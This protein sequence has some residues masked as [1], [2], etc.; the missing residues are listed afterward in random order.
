M[1]STIVLAILAAIGACRALA[2]P[3]SFAAADIHSSP[4]ATD[5]SG[6]ITRGSRI[7]LRGAT[8]THLISV[9]YDIAQDRIV[10]GPKW[11]DVDRFDVIAAAPQ[12]ASV[13]ELQQM[14]K[15]LLAERFELKI[16][17][18]EIPAAVYVLTETK[19]GL[20]KSSTSD[21]DGECVHPVDNS[22][23]RVCMGVSIARLA[24]M[25]PT[26]APAYFDSPIVDRTGDR[27]RYDFNLK[28]TGRAMLGAN[29]ESVSLYDYLG[30]ELGIK[31]QKGSEPMPAILVE[32]VHQV[33]TPNAANVRDAIPSP[34]TEF[35]AAEV[36]PDNI[37][38]GRNEFSYQHGRLLIERI[39]AKA[40]IAFGYGV[41]QDRIVGGPSW[42]SSEL[43]DLVAKADPTVTVADMR[44]MLQK[45]LAERFHL[46]LHDEK[47][48]IAVYGLTATKDIRLRV[49][50]PAARG[51]C[52][53]SV[54]TGRRVYTCTNTS[55]PELAARLND[56]AREYLDRLAVD[57][58]GLN[59]SYD[60]TIS[61]SPLQRTNSPLGAP[62]KAGA[63][64]TLPELADPT[65]G[66]TLSEGLAKI[67]LKL[68]SQRRPLP[69]LVIDNVERP[70][71]K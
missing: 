22:V 16:R 70:I 71:E 39:T 24:E 35:E 44:P 55:M 4:P 60:F 46:A 26:L 56:D 31:V 66:I 38:G 17:R 48:P 41:G 49:G 68:V 2:Q 69:A 54:D 65:G 11:I 33:P 9:A 53:I 8:M 15:S 13:S 40:I 47:R 32:S 59:G 3:L 1:G 37:E 36:K 27:G 63:S 43:F 67:G 61:W 50:N 28:W 51:G 6:A 12:A 34:P 30:K 14:L 58:T 25:L 7:S 18:A 10:N 45:L 62:S 52:R 23:N 5:Q 29:P 19:R 20:L 42:V 64:G 21:H 57:L